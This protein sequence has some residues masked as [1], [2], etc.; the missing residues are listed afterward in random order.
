[1]ARAARVRQRFNKESTPGSGIYPVEIELQDGCWRTFGGTR[2]EYI[3]LAG[4]RVPSYRGTAWKS[5]ADVGCGVWKLRLELRWN[6]RRVV[7]DFVS[8]AQSPRLGRAA[9]LVA[10]LPC[11]SA[12]LL[13]ALLRQVEGY[14]SAESDAELDRRGTRA[15]RILLPRRRIPKKFADRL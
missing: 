5:S 15:C 6:L 14:G 10:E 12:H 3:D 7:E 13:R 2:Q 1:M 4:N 9:I 11:A 8:E